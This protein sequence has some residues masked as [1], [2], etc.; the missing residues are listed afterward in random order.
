MGEN[1]APHPEL[2]FFS[3]HIAQTIYWRRNYFLCVFSFSETLDWWTVPFKPFILQGHDVAPQL[4]IYIYIYTNLVNQCESRSFLL[5]SLSSME[6]QSCH[7][8]WAYVWRDRELNR[9]HYG[10]C[11][12]HYLV[13]E[14]LLWLTKPRRALMRLRQ[15]DEKNG[16]WLHRGTKGSSLWIENSNVSYG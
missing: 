8:L 3:C 7:V 14:K 5:L 9:G 10:P 1:S 13:G 15:Y 2:K 12:I 11:S 4:Y 6:L 16:A